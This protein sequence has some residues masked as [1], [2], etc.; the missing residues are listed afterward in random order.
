MAIKNLSISL[1]RFTTT[2]EK[3]EK[4]AA[5]QRSVPEA[6][7]SATVEKD[8]KEEIIELPSKFRQFNSDPYLNVQSRFGLSV[9][10]IVKVDNVLV[11]E[12]YRIPEEYKY[13]K[14]T[15]FTRIYS[16][17]LHEIHRSYQSQSEPTQTHRFLIFIQT[18]RK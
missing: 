5:N 12:G 4:V 9:N 8:P 6:T 10:D 7:Y 17:H 13:S 11:S 18:T 1:D 2:L 14:V 3:V 16:S 15:R